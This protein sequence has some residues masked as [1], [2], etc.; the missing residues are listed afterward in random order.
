M[1]LVNLGIATGSLV[2]LLGGSSVA[3]LHAVRRVDQAEVRTS[4]LTTP[5]VEAIKARNYLQ[6]VELADAAIH[7]DPGSGWGYYDRAD[8]LT[9]L[10]RTDDAVTAFREAERR[11]SQA[12]P[13]ATSIAI[14]G[15]ANALAEVGRCHEA[16]PMFERY[17]VLVS[18]TDRG[19]AEMARLYA[20][21]CNPRLG[22]H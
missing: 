20:K 12:D 19:S 9:Y 1:K 6:A 10:R 22:D 21:R 8:A 18:A 11:F 17:A 2:L 15:A 14:W 16:A 5:A 3:Q 7:A 13:W 4:R